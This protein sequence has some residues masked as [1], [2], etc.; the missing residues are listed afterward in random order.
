MIYFIGCLK[1]VKIDVLLG[2][3]NILSNVHEGKLQIHDVTGWNLVDFGWLRRKYVL[4]AP[5]FV[6][7]VSQD[8]Q[9]FLF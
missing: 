6:V 9:V 4:I 7:D 5:G 3:V 8:S 1:F 2:F